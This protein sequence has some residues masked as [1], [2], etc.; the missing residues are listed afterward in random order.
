M[1]LVIL[2]LPIISATPYISPHLQVDPYPFLFGSPARCALVLVYLFYNKLNTLDPLL[3]PRS[4]GLQLPLQRDHLRSS[5]K[6][7][8][9]LFLSKSKKDQQM[10]RGHSKKCALPLGTVFEDINHL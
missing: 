10:R 7:S 6:R 3:V 5:K 9:K 2:V 8:E 1:Y 4:T